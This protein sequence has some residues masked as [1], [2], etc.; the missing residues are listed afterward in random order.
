MISK[1]IG[2]IFSCVF[3]F[4]FSFLSPLFNPE[5]LLPKETDC[6]YLKKLQ[7]KNFFTI[8]EDEVVKCMQEL[9]RAVDLNPDR[10]ITDIFEDIKQE[11]DSESKTC[12]DIREL[13]SRLKDPREMQQFPYDNIAYQSLILLIRSWPKK[14]CH[15]H[16]SPSLSVQW[17]INTIRKHLDADYKETFHE[18]INGASWKNW[19]E[20]WKDTVTFEVIKIFD[21]G[22]PTD[23]EIKKLFFQY[24]NPTDAFDIPILFTKG[25]SAKIFVEA[26]R[27]VIKTY[28]SDGVCYL[29]LRFNPCK[30]FKGEKIDVL[31]MLER[32]Y[33]VFKEEEARVLRES[34]IEHKVNLVC[35]LNIFNYADK[36]DWLV[37]CMSKIVNKKIENNN[38]GAVSR[39]VGIDFSGQENEDSMRSSWSDIQEIVKRA[40]NNGIEFK[41][42]CHAGD[43]WNLSDDYN[44][45]LD[46]HLKFL[47][48]AVN[49]EGVSAIGHGNVL[50]PLYK[51]FR[52]EDSNL[53]RTFCNGVTV[54]QK[55]KIDE[56]IDLIIKKNIILEALPQAEFKC[57]KNIE[58]HYS[59][60]YWKEKGVK[61][62]L[63]LDGTIYMPG[64]L[65]EWISWLL[66][67]TS[68]FTVSEAKEMV[69]CEGYK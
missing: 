25:D 12:I 1:L 28:F 33:V 21:S 60:S 46:N 19:R 24:K 16:I 45:Y 64:G 30:E 11:F 48:D 26:V 44:L 39:V 3:L 9:H 55:Q 13:L 22:Q 50:S 34:G 7:D 51:T 6:I 68:N 18:Y 56:I 38:T 69:L 40:N 36:K 5:S 42:V 65:S 10:H 35:S 14:D 59:F 32:L 54:A 37:E 63:G 66:L 62:Q 67:T 47:E 4:S 17:V 53:K 2:S 15:C 29:E 52:P 58:N 43:R 57:I 23:H 41:F 20:K 27:S 49:I 8:Y 61:L 31:G